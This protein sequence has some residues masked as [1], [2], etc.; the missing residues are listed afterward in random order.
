MGNITLGR[1][2]P[3]DSPIHKLDPR[4]KIGAMIITLIAIFFPAGWIGYGIIFA[5]V[6]YVIIRSKLSP[7]FIWK[8][9]TVSGLRIW[10]SFTETVPKISQNPPRN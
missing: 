9:S 3:L 6:S 1:Y 4:A 10:S 5:A 7:V 2:I 8:V